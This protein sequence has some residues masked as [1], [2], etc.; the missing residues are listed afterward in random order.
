MNKKTHLLKATFIL[1]PLLILL[2]VTPKVSGQANSPQID[3]QV[4]PTFEGNFKYGEWL[5]LWITLENTGADAEIEVTANITGSSG[6]GIFAVEVSLPAGARKQVPLYIIPNNFSREIEIQVTNDGNDLA[7]K[8]IEVTPNQNNYFLVGVAS[9]ETGAI[10]QLDNLTVGNTSR[11]VIYFNLFPNLLPEKSIALNS[12][13][14]IV[15]NDT[16]TSQLNPEQKQALME[17]IQQG[18]RLILGGGPG[19]EKTLAGLPDEFIKFSAN[20]L[21]ETEALTALEIY[22]N[23]TPIRV[24]GPFTFNQISFNAGTALVSQDDQ[25][26]VHTFS[27]GSGNINLITLDLST[28]P[29]DAWSGVSVFWQNLLSPGSSYPMWMPLDTSIRQIRA[30]SMYYPLTNQPSL[31]LPSIRWLGILLV[32]YILLV[33]PINYLVLRWRKKSQLA[34]V[35]IPVLT[36]LFTAGAF[37]LAFLLRGNDILINNISIINL[38]ADGSANVT[39]YVGVFSPSQSS[40]TLEV[41]G[42][43]L[44]SASSQGYYDPWSSVPATGGDT[45]FVQ[46]NPATVS[47]L[48]V[49]QWSLNSFNIEGV[50]A[51]MGTIK[52][53]LTLEKGKLTGAI[54][55]QLPYT[56]T[57]AVLVFGTSSE[58]LGD[59]EPFQPLE[60]EIDFST[61][62][63]FQGAPSS[64]QIIEKAA[65]G[66]EEVL[67]SREY[68]QKRSI[69]DATLQPYGYWMGMNPGFV[70]T[71]SED[72]LQLSSTFLLGWLDTSPIEISLGGKT[73]NQKSLSLLSYYIP[74]NIDPAGFTLPTS[75]IPGKLT[76]TSNNSGYCGGTETYIYFDN[77]E[78]TFNFNVPINLIHADIDSFTL[79]VWDDMHW[80]SNSSGLSL[81]FYNWED[82]NWIE[83][84]EI[85]NG[86]NTI[87]NPENLVSTDGLVQI[88]ATRTD[89]NTGGCI[90]LALGLDGS[91][92]N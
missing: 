90:Y 13:D 73:A 83:Y 10:T 42:S 61:T 76:S 37:G 58:I 62:R 31:D 64:Y 89:N 26:L 17:W 40:Y 54:E 20:N 12:L 72:E 15:L 56:I 19:L 67:Y 59:L 38:L 1:L 7:S 78:A 27:Y 30:G 91:L 47:G 46:G 43:P 6:S 77:N 81:A 68:E 9:P 74:M 22:A 51:E 49:N 87:K 41:S 25:P 8:T 3:I 28:S 33:G 4:T 71:Q 79:D 45:R 24:N 80:D 92:D 86:L 48:N 5:L 44:L 16:D 82:H 29:F 2:A 66:T 84:D 21:L 55:N 23:E 35:S 63:I 34:W 18:G 75:T 32:V 85:I 70:G 57:G 39:G 69:L 52:T 65:M 53:D 14:A 88:K 50:R 60:I 11:K 36:A